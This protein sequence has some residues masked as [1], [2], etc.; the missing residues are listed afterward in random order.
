[1]FNDY[2][3]PE[4]KAENIN[5]KSGSTNFQTCG[6][7]EHT[8]GGTCRY[9]C[10]IHGSCSYLDK[11][12]YYDFVKN[13]GTEVFWDTKCKLLQLSKDDMKDWTTAWH[14]KIEEE[15]RSLRYREKEREDLIK[16]TETMKQRPPLA[17]FRE[18]DFFKDGDKVR[19]YFNQAFL[20]K[21]CPDMKNK[22]GYWFKATVV[23]GYRSGDGCVSYI[24]DLIEK[25]KTNGPWGSGNA[26][27]Q[28]IH[29]WE[30]EYFLKNPDFWQWWK[31]QA[32]AK[33]YNGD[34]LSLDTLE[35]ED[36][37]LLN[38]SKELEAKE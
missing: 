10:T 17:E 28:V 2:K 31:K 23:P 11:M 9:S 27:P 25:S 16:L 4:W 38:T 33:S 34:R 5:R 37:A 19:V 13:T 18:S 12:N 29:E 6:W 35:G 32:E 21:S 3:E 22:V 26:V 36:I 7:C 8:S 30:Y 15:R 14:Y 24:I 20:V 1:M